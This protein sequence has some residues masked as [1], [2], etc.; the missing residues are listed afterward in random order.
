M[1]SKKKKRTSTGSS[2]TRQSGGLPTPLTPTT[3]AKQDAQSQRSAVFA[4]KQLASSTIAGSNAA[5]DGGRTVV[6]SSEDFRRSG[7]SVRAE[8]LLQPCS[9]QQQQQQLQTPTTADSSAASLQQAV[10]AC[11]KQLQSAALKAGQA[12]CSSQLLAALHCGEGTKATIT[13]LA[14][15]TYAAVVPATRLH[16]HLQRAPS[17]RGSE[18]AQYL[19]RLPASRRALLEKAAA[20]TAEDLCVRSGDLLSVSFE[21]LQHEFAVAEL[22]PSAE[23]AAI[24]SSSTSADATATTT[25]ETTAAG[26]STAAPTNDDTSSTTAGATADTLT[27]DTAAADNTAAAA[28]RAKL[29]AFY[30]HHNAEKLGEVDIILQRYAGRTDAMFAKLYAKYGVA[31]DAASDVADYVTAQ[32]LTQTDDSTAVQS[33]EQTDA[34]QKDAVWFWRIEA[35]TR[36]SIGVEQPADTGE[37]HILLHHRPLHAFIVYCWACAVYGFDLTLVALAAACSATPTICAH[38]Y[39]STVVIQYHAA[40]SDSAVT[41]PTATTSS[42]DRSS[43]SSSASTAQWDTAVGG[44]AAQVQQLREAVELPL[45]SPEVFEKYGVRPPRGVLLHGPPGTGKKYKMFSIAR[46]RALQAVP[47]CDICGCTTL[48]RAAAAACGAH[49][50][51]INGPELLSS[52][53]ST[54]VF[55]ISQQPLCASALSITAIDI[56]AVAVAMNAFHITRLALNSSALHCC[57]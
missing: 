3:P 57:C 46:N 23:S 7:F 4:L 26:V 21:G 6:L 53:Q 24:I 52:V 25:I 31:D 33:A 15:C 29:L 38:S 1:S 56:T 51:A 44:L 2:T 32:Q 19:Q 5:L 45:R 18:P 55:H 35:S 28:V 54:V 12:G 8:V 9:K 36:C 40:S 49:V 20:F 13:A 48:A 39:H 16:L 17:S 42:T 10:I 50:I 11:V 30:K 47:L 27:A 14:A 34:V 43:S 41:N 22:E 37:A